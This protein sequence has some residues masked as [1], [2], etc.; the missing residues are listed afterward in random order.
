MQPNAIKD[1]VIVGGG[2]A[3]WMCA[4]AMARM[5]GDGVNITLVESEQI[6]TVGVGEATIPNIAQFNQM[7]GIDEAEF[8]AATHGTFKLGIEFVNWGRKGERYLHPFGS[9]GVD[10]DGIAFHQYWAR[11]RA[12]G[13]DSSIEAYS[14]SAIAARAGKFIHPRPEPRSILN[15]ISY[16]YQFDAT[17]YAEYLRKYAEKCGVT[18]VEGLVETVQQNAENGFVTGVTLRGGR[19]IE[20][21]LFFDCTGFRA[22]L[23]GKTLGVEYEDWSHWLPCDSAQAIACDIHGP[24]IPYTRA[25]AHSAG[26]QWRI[27]TQHRTGNGHVY[28]SAY[29]SD[30]E[31]GQILMNNLDGKAH[32]DAPKQLR[33]ITGKRRKLWDKNVI[34]LGLSGGFLEPLEST[35]IYLIQAGISR[36]MGLFPDKTMADIDRDEYNRLLDKEF[37]QVRDFIILHYVATQRDDSPFWNYVRTMD[38]PDSLT[39]KIELFKSS[40]RFFRYDGELFTDTSWIAVLLGQ[41]IIPER[42]DPIVGTMP[43]ARITESLGSMRSAM[44][45]AASQMPIHDDYISKFCPS[46]LRAK[47]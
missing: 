23:I 46:P 3:G 34:S 21:D 14:L 5:L 4:A 25:T 30:D 29:M 22:M 44:E 43:L 15:H 38:I 13:D 37:A 9:H 18:R 11:L 8:M 24:V 2:T 19:N 20:G 39:R 47:P 10:M 28:S 12:Q 7:L 6:G 36:F 41:N 42:Y 35:S 33:F 40:G 1:I 31:A 32:R 16:A 26:W 27:P 17:A 45:K